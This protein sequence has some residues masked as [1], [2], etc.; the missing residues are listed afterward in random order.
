M[1]GRIDFPWHLKA[2]AC[3]RGRPSGYWQCRHT[4][5]VRPE[6]KFVPRQ[7]VPQMMT[8]KSVKS[9]CGRSHHFAATRI[10]VALGAKRT[11]S[12]ACHAS[13]PPAGTR[14][15]TRHRA[16]RKVAMLPQHVVLAKIMRELSEYPH[17]RIWF[18][19]LLCTM[20]MMLACTLA[21]KAR[22]WRCYGH[23]TMRNPAT[24]D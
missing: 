19:V 15:E 10:S 5:F 1:T 22:S 17:A 7:R 14:S 23:S 16:R 4:T 6:L 20:A 3:E 8:N 13:P 12:C 24:K 21:A 9:G 18:Q 2:C 11:L